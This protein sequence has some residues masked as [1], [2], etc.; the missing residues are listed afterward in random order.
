MADEKLRLNTA[1]IVRI[2]VVQLAIGVWDE[3]LNSTL[4]NVL[5]LGFGKTETFKGMII[6]ASQLLTML[7]LPVWGSMSDRCR[8]KRGRR[9]PFILTGGFVCA[10]VLSLSVLFY[11]NNN[12]VGFLICVFLCAVAVCMVNPAATALV[13]DLTPKPLNANASVINRIVCSLGGAWVVML[14][15][16]FDTDFTVIY[17]TAAGTI[18]NCTLFYLFA[19]PENKLL[20]KQKPLLEK[21][22]GKATDTQTSLRVMLNLLSADEKRSFFGILTANFF[23]KL[24]YYAFSSAYLN[25][26]VTQWDMKYAHTGLLTIAIYVAGLVSILLTAKAAAKIGRKRTL[27]I[28]YLFMLLGFAAA[29]VTKNFGIAAIA[30]LLLIGIGWSMESVLPLPMLME[31]TG[32]GTVGIVTSVYTDSCKL[33]RVFGPFLTGLLL[34]GSRWGYRSLYPFAALS[35][36]PAILTVPMIRHGNVQI[37]EVNNDE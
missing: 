8:A 25:Y 6:A 14:I 13:P 11:E 5:V 3:L 10:I 18:L 7:L 22:N 24:A 2:S 37:R 23:A 30:A 9:S 36:L 32:S 34:D 27:L 31:M 21:Y 1:L 17:L 16:F 19:V 26:A 4:Q 20:A 12:L 15:L 35:M 33:G 28:S 29:A